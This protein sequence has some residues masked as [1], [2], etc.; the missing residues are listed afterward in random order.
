M[1][2]YFGDEKGAPV[3]ILFVYVSLAKVTS[4]KAN[5]EN[6]AKAWYV[7]EIH[8]YHFLNFEI[9]KLNQAILLKH[10]STMGSCVKQY[11]SL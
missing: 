9:N 10:H 5:I 4:S 3:A 2:K 1:M 8:S 11:Q 7:H 6:S